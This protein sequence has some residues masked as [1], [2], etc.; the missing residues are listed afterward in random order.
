MALKSAVCRLHKLH[1]YIAT[2][3]AILIKYGTYNYYLLCSYTYITIYLL[4]S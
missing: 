1:T 4:Y 2:L 3:C